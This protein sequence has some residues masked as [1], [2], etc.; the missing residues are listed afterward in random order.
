[1]YYRT[2]QNRAVRWLSF[3]SFDPACTSPVKIV[4]MNASLSGDLAAHFTD[5]TTAANIALINQ[6]Y[7]QTPFLQNTSEATRLLYAMHPEK[8]SCVVPPRTRAVR[9]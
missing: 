6:S 8:D 1:V 3:S 7:D 9:R 4:D 2:D 5:Y